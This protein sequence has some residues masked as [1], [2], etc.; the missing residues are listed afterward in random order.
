MKRNISGRVLVAL[1]AVVLLIGCA[2][3]SYTHL[4]VY[5]RQ[6]QCKGLADSIHR[7]TYGSFLFN[8]ACLAD[9]EHCESF[10]YKV[11]LSF[12]FIYQ[13]IDG[14]QGANAA[15]QLPKSGYSLKI[16]SSPSASETP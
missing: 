4:D 2:A 3:V 11:F 9:F 12:L 5:K 7:S 15:C 6:S 8:P 10:H 1:V 13:E 14:R 16:N